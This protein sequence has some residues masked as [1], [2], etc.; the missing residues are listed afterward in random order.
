VAQ[1]F[2]QVASEANPSVSLRWGALESWG[3]DFSTL[4]DPNH[5]DIPTSLP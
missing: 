5:F 3:G 1:I 4:Q 2:K